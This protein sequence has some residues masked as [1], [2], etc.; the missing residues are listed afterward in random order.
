MFISFNRINEKDLF[1]FAK[2]GKFYFNNE[3]KSKGVMEFYERN[4]VFKAAERQIEKLEGLLKEKETLLAT[5]QDDSVA[6][7]D[8]I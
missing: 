3:D 4:G 2:R 1:L 7:M 8:L 5:M 6:I